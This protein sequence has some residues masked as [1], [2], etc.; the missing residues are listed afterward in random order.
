MRLRFTLLLVLAAVANFTLAANV[1]VVAPQ[2]CAL[3]ASSD[4]QVKDS[5]ATAS[6]GQVLALSGSVYGDAVKVKVIVGSKGAK[7]G[8]VAWMWARGF[9]EATKGKAVVVGKQFIIG[10]QDAPQGV[11]LFNDQS[12]SKSAAAGVLWPGDTVE[13]LEVAITWRGVLGDK[14]VYAPYV[15]DVK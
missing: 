5:V 12:W 10:G 3:K 15:K 7:A 14:W 8:T 2:G 6:N 11:G 13:T 1:Q 9:T 4:W